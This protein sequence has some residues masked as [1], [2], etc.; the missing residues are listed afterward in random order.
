MIQKNVKNPRLYKEF[1]M[2]RVVALVIFT[3]GSAQASDLSQAWKDLSRY[4]VVS[5]IKAVV[6]GF[7]AVHAAHQGWKAGK[8]TLEVLKSSPDKPSLFSWD[9]GNEAVGNTVLTLGMFYVAGILTWDYFP[10]YTKH[11]LAL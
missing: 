2:K 9:R 6:V 7:A 11:A 3:L 1:F 5:G 8:N 10:G 4:R